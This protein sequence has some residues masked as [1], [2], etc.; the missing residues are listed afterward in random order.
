MCIFFS[1]FITRSSFKWV[2]FTFIYFIFTMLWN[3]MHTEKCALCPKTMGTEFLPQ[4]YYS[5]HTE[6]CCTTVGVFF[7]WERRIVTTHVGFCRRAI[8]VRCKRKIGCRFCDGI[9]RIPM[10]ILWTFYCLFLC[11]HSLNIMGWNFER[12]H[13]FQ[14]VIVL[15]DLIVL[16]VLCAKMSHPLKTYVD[17]SILNFLALS[18][19]SRVWSEFCS[20]IPK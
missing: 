11:Q 1:I 2:I 10:N 15:F 18:P 16:E 19:L 9:S 7:V 14:N 13:K 5:G 12:P 3:E 8:L 17:S 4:G 6:S 20:S